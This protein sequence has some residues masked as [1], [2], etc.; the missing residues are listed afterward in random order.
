M[1]EKLRFAAEEDDEGELDLNYKG[2]TLD[3]AER[4]SRVLRENPA[5]AQGIKQLWLKYNQDLGDAGLVALVK[6]FVEA[7]GLEGGRGAGACSVGGK[8]PLEMLYICYCGVSDLSLLVSSPTVSDSSWL[9][10][11]K[12][13]SFSEDWS[14]MEFPAILCFELTSLEMLYLDGN[15]NLRLPAELWHLPKKCSIR[16]PI[17][18]RAQVARGPDM[19]GGFINISEKFMVGSSCDHNIHALLSEL[20]IEEPSSGSVIKSANKR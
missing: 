17:G 14:S 6:A 7:L 15:N 19:S 10:G 2:L 4:L 5:Y 18:K 13:L 9:S 1:K 20:D 11:L 12:E 8:S 16:L 3:G